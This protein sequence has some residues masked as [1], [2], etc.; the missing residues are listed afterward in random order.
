MHAIFNRPA[1][2]AADADPSTHFQTKSYCLL[3]AG[4]KEILIIHEMKDP[5]ST[6]K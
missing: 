2:F 5:A 4:T 1:A 3:G 6:A